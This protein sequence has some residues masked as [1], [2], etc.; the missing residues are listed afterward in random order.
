MPIVPVPTPSAPPAAGPY[1][2]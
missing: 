1:S 2:P